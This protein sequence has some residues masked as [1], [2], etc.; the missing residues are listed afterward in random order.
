[1]IAP[2]DGSIGVLRRAQSGD[3]LGSA[4]GAPFGVAA[5]VTGRHLRRHHIML[6]STL[7]AL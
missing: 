6:A 7:F 2:Q 1:M 3:G 4:G 5:D